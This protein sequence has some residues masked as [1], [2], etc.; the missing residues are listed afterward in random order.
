M[1]R[2]PA[3]E[4]AEKHER[5]LQEASRLFRENGLS[6]VS[7]GDLMQAADLTHGSFY[8]HFESKQAL[9]GK[10]IDWLNPRAVGR[11]GSAMPT[12]AGKRAFVSKYLSVAS[13]DEP[14]QACLMSTLGPEIA[15]EPAARAAMTNY[16]QTFVN[17]LV[18]HFPWPRPAAARKDAIRMTA[19]LVGAMVLA[20]SVDDDTLSRE[21]LREVI[22][23]FTEGGADTRKPRRA[24]G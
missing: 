22:G 13:R 7:V 15:R 23:Q 19:S 20:R 6:G 16:V 10:C 12:E 4:T 3:T 21:I 9:V 18:S 2:Y 11:I 1:P 5:I 24:A 8:N 17:K 14:G